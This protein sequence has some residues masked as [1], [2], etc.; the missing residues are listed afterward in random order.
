MHQTQRPW[1]H[2]HPQ[3]NLIIFGQMQLYI[4]QSW[5][6]NGSTSILVE[7]PV[8]ASS[9]YFH[10]ASRVVNVCIQFHHSIFT[11]EM[12]ASVMALCVTAH[13]RVCYSV[14]LVVVGLFAFHLI[15]RSSVSI[16]LLFNVSLAQTAVFFAFICCIGF[17]SCI[18]HYALKVSV[19][20]RCQCLC[21]GLVSISKTDAYNTHF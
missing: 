15:F 11:V 10:L 3:Y 9:H 20:I 18:E 19:E 14:H 7:F 5:S 8:R 2:P 4:M 12:Y 1:W 16:Q 13:C 17:A 6:M 21:R